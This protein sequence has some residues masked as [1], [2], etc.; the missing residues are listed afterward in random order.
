[1]KSTRNGFLPLKLK[2]LLYIFLSDRPIGLEINA[3]S[4]A[5]QQ[6]LKQQQSIGST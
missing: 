1:M 3:V 4:S 2:G 5:L 6:A